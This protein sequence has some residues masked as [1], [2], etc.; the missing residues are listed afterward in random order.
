MAFV[1]TIMLGNGFDLN[2]GLKTRYSDFFA[3]IK[4]NYPE[5]IETN[6]IYY[7]MNKDKKKGTRN[8]ADVEEAIS[9]TTF[10]IDN[11]VKYNAVNNGARIDNKN[12]NLFIPS[13]LGEKDIKIYFYESYFEFNSDFNKYITQEIDKYNI[14]EHLLIKNFLDSLRFMID[15]LFEKEKDRIE[16]SLKNNDYNYDK[17]GNMRIYIEYNFIVFN[18]TKIIEEKI[19]NNKEIYMN[20]LKLFEKELSDSF[21]K[22]FNLAEDILIS[23]NLVELDKFITNIHCGDD[24]FP[25]LGLSKLEHI[26]EGFYENSNT[27]LKSNYTKPLKGIDFFIVYS[28]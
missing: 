21:I 18:Y 11:Y 10:A 1:Q 8:W 27:F 15:N 26:S 4:E 3:Y 6:G 12:L 22:N 13:N 23:T 16:K 20:Q 24:D 5:K 7:L 19:F 17:N 9:L 14:D 2:L 28:F 25:I